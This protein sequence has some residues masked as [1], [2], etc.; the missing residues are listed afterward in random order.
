[1]IIQIMIPTMTMMEH[2]VVGNNCKTKQ[3]VTNLKYL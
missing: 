1:M 3:L 2:I